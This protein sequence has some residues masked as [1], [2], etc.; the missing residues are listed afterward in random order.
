M[1]SL[2]RSIGLLAITLGLFAWSGPGPLA[3]EGAATAPA[4]PVAV[5]D[6]RR[7]FRESPVAR[8]AKDDFR[9]TMRALEEKV[10]SEETRLRREQ[11]E[12]GDVRVPGHPE[13]EK[14][15]R[16]L[17]IRA[18][19][20]KID[21]ESARQSIVTRYLLVRR[22]LYGEIAAEA[23]SIAREHGYEVVLNHDPSPLD[24]FGARS[25]EELDAQVGARA[26]LYH[27]SAV[28]LTEAVLARIAVGEEKAHD[29]DG[30][31]APGESGGR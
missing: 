15:R 25:L 5:V 23:G 7:I 18:A 30:S 8:K 12:L 27:A 1:K 17:A 16:E 28:D 26:V 11:E 9:T 29:S 14:R 24:S 2:S 10:A 31:D 4:G 19:T 13:T 20:L 21:G 6:V 3:S 22:K